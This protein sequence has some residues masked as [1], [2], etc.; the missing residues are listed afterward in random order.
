[1]AQHAARVDQTASKST[2]DA[3]LP[4]AAF[5]RRFGLH[6]LAIVISLILMLPFF[7]ALSSSLKQVGEV[8]QIPPLWLPSVPQWHNYADVWNVRLFPTWYWN[9]IFLTAIATTGTVLSSS[10]AGYAFA[11]FRFPFKNVLFSLTMATLFLP[12]L[13]AAD[14]ELLALL[15]D[16]LAEH[17]PATHD[18]VL[19][20][21]GLL[22]L[23]VPAVLHGSSA[24]TG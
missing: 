3:L 14:P 6:L 1:M 9:T 23:L 20:R 18:P 19:V 10:L 8:R 7:W 5:L 15:E 4:A 22:H 24:G 17:L 11:R 12:G 21:P 13:R 2:A 16:R